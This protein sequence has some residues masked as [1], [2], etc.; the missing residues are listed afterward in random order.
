VQ[1]PVVHWPSSVQGWPCASFGTQT[2]P[3]QTPVAQAVPATAGWQVPLEHVKHSGHAE[4]VVPTEQ[5]ST[6]LL[7]QS[8]WLQ[9]GKWSTQA[10]A[11]QTLQSPQMVPSTHGAAVVVV[12]VVAPPI[13]VPPEQEPGG[14]HRELP[15]G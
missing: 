4:Q 10:P 5:P 3:L 13:S 6:D 2:P 9:T 12:V 7:P 8:P 15:L 14:R 11:L 1:K